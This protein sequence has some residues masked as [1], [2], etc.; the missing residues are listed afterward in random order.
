MD[1]IATC[2]VVDIVLLPEAVRTFVVLFVPWVAFICYVGSATVRTA[3]R[4][5]DLIF[6][7]SVWPCGAARQ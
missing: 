3:V 5:T 2:I 6:M 1:L 7:I 4:A